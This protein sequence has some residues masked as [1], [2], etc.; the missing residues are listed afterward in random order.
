MD[1]YDVIVI[2]AGPA[3][4]SA[5]IYLAR[6]KRKVLIIDSEK[7][8]SMIPGVYSNIMGF[9]EP[10]SRREYR[11]LGAEQAVRYGA[12]K[13]CEEAKDVIIRDDG[14]FEVVCVNSTYFSKY[15]IFCTGVVDR[16]ANI[17]GIG[18]YIG[19]VVHSCTVCAGYE[20]AGKSVIGIGNDEKA[21]RFALS[22]QNYTDKIILTTN[23][24]P[25]NIEDSYLNKVKKAGIPV[26]TNKIVKII[27]HDKKLEKVIFDDG[28]EINV[29]YIFCQLGVKVNSRLARKI[30]VKTNE[31]G[32]IIVD[33]KQK[34]NIDRIYAA[35]DVTTFNHKQV[36]TA[37]YE[38]FNA[39][40]A[41][42][43][44]MLRER[45]CSL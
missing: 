45:I 8:R 3:G 38:G 27:G 16:W 32:Y 25:L 21:T 36:V 43:S 41:I 6:F 9:V 17:E 18:E 34:T 28:R 14:I 10:V 15:I 11:K 26:Y 35:G 20:T 2:G 42:N 29:D 44:D 31:I 13:V 30:G 7:G 12:H 19:Y 39:A 23:G 5:G 22:M 24:M 33:D 1:I 4:L 40:F 37:L